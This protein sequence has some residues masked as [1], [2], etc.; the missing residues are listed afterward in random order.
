MN[1]A[2][3]PDRPGAPCTRI[4]SAYRALEPVRLRF[5]QHTGRDSIP[6]SFGTGCGAELPAIARCPGDRRIRTAA[7]EVIGIEGGVR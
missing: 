1:P 6:S 3:C 4:G 7:H 5:D 2:S